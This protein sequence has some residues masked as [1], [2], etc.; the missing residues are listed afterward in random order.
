[1]RAMALSRKSFG[2]IVIMTAATAGL[3]MNA[4]PAS[5]KITYL[6]GVC[7]GDDGGT[8]GS[9]VGILV[10]STTQAPVAIMVNGVTLAGSPFVPSPTCGL[11]E[12]GGTYGA[13]INVTDA[14]GDL[15]IV[16]TQKDADGTTSQ[17]TFDYSYAAAHG[18]NTGSSG[19]TALTGSS[20]L[21]STG[22][23]AFTSIANILR[24]LPTGSGTPTRAC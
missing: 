1:M 21:I 13:D 2:T 19:I 10:E 23:S 6:V 12:G 11:N 8:C 7:G 18:N 14:S 24:G 22:S 3:V 20:N 4:A 5:A 17:M 16:A 9:Q 15:H